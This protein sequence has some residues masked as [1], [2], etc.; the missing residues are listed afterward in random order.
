MKHGRALTACSHMVLRKYKEYK[1]YPW[2][3]DQIEEFKDDGFLECWQNYNISVVALTAPRF[4][5]K[6][7]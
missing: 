5:H 7:Y 1:T 4:H 2:S 3:S 6:S